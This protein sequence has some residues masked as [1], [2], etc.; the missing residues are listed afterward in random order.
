MSNKINRV[1]DNAFLQDPYGIAAV[2][3]NPASGGE[4]SLIVGPRL[5]P[6]QVASGYT[7][8]VSS[9]TALPYLGALLAIYNNSGTAGSVTTGKNNTITALAIGVTDSNGNVGVACPPNTYTYLSMGNNQW[10][11]STASTLI[12]YIIEDPTKIAQETGPYAQQ[13]A[14]NTQPIS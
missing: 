7:T 8:N 5:I 4:K 10:I 11:I 13:N 9:V 3:Y 6:I 1:I 12:V 14:A 2:E